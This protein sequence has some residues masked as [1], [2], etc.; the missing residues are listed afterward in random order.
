MTTPNLGESSHYKRRVWALNI[1]H[2]LL[3]FKEFNQLNPSDIWTPHGICAP[4][5]KAGEDDRDVGRKNLQK[6]N[7]Q[8]QNP[9]AEMGTND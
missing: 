5:A 9:V 7:D 8:T 4:R 6:N 2:V 3:P 1:G